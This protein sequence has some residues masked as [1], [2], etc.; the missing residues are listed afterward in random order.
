MTPG[1]K[2]LS[3][4]ELDQLDAALNRAANSYT[5][6]V[7]A[8]HL[9]EDPAVCSAWVGR[10]YAGLAEDLTDETALYAI[11]RL[12]QDRAFEQARK[13]ITGLRHVERGTS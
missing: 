12:I 3:G 4:P 2:A 7:V 9:G 1:Y 10:I 6:L 5:S 8:Q 13:V 11:V